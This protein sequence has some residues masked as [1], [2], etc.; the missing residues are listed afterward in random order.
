MRNQ[1][2]HNQFFFEQVQKATSGRFELIVVDNGS[3]DGSRNFSTESAPHVTRPA[4]ISVIP[5][6]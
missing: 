2:A 6:R 1:L 4:E 3:T 5:N